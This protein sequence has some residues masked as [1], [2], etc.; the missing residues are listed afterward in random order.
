MLEQQ[1]V[2]TSLGT[3]CVLYPPPL[4]MPTHPFLYTGVLTKGEKTYA[5]AS[6]QSSLAS[7]EQRAEN[8]R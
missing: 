8:L 5:S 7:Q 3:D 1:S 4:N 6:S 2:P